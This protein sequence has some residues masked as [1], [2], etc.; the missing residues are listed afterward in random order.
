MSVGV[1]Q[2]SGVATA[3]LGRALGNTFGVWAPCAFCPLPSSSPVQVRGWRPRRPRYWIQRPFSDSCFGRLRRLRL[4]LQRSHLH[5]PRVPRRLPSL[6]RQR[7]LFLPT[8]GQAG[9]LSTPSATR[10]SGWSRPMARSSGRG[11][12]RGGAASRLQATTRSS[13][14]PGR[15]GRGA[16]P[17]WITWSGSHERPASR[18]ASTRSPGC[19]GG[20]SRASRSWEPS[21][22]SAACASATRMRSRCGTGRTSALPWWCCP[23]TSSPPDPSSKS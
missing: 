22:A 13:P 1:G 20:P 4:L 5:R 19:G 10:E 3:I 23:S 16:A 15:H 12:C 9:A 14:G 8:R 6:D 21:R 11:R 2:A 18:S 17:R 7:P